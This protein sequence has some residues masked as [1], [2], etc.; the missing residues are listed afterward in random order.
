MFDV[1]GQR[2]ERKKW[3]HCF[4]G[5]T[6]IIFCVDVAEYDLTLAEDYDTV[7]RIVLT[8]KSSL[9]RGRFHESREMK[10]GKAEEESLWKSMKQIC[11][12]R[13][14][15]H[16]AFAESNDGEHGAVRLDLQQQVVRE[17]V[18][19]PLP[20]QDGPLPGEDQAVTDHDLLPG[21]QR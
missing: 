16:L 12:L 21:V 1:G 5:V 19:H 6:A 7:S 10:V 8:K 9:R 15:L 20:E 17:D 11:T 13:L 3:I 2:T 14:Q 18:D 4:E